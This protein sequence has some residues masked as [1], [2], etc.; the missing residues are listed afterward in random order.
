MGPIGTLSV[1]AVD[2]RIGCRLEIA[3]EAPT[4]MLAL[5]HPHTS[6]RANL[7]DPEQVFLQPD[8]PVEVLTD[9]KGNRWCRFIAASG[10]TRFGYDA[11]I[12]RPDAGD[13]VVPAAALCPVQFLPI[14]TYPFLNAS[15]YC[16]TAALMGLAWA[17]FSQVPAGWAR[18]QAICDWIHA[19]IRFDYDA[20][21]PEKTASQTLAD[22]AGVCRDF[23]H[24]AISLCRCLNIPARYCTGYLGYTGIPVT[25]APV[26]FSAWFDVFLGDRWY[27]FDARHNMPRC[28]R[29]LIAQGRDAGDVPFLRSFGEHRLVRLEVITEAIASTMAV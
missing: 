19:Q 14:D 17:T 21:T 25:E 11:S 9:G 27:T 23:A 15:T 22:G 24:L 28:G 7:L 5:V 26:D 16:D 12:E 13:L 29:V 3:C 4:P 10:S 20:V 18:V 8:R 2:L 6:L 1:T